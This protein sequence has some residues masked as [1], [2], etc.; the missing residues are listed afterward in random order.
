MSFQTLGPNQTSIY[1]R[2]VSSGD[3]ANHSG[4]LPTVGVYFDEM[5]VTTI[6]GTLDMNMYDTS[7]IEVLPGPQGTLYGASS[8]AGTVRIISN[9]ATPDKFSAGYSLEGNTTAGAGG[10]DLDGF[11]NVPLGDKAAIRLVGWGQRTAGYLDNVYAT[12]TYTTSGYT[13]NDKNF[14]G[15]NENPSTNNGGRGSLLLN[16]TPHWSVTLNAMGEDQHID[17]FYGYLPEVG[18]LKVERFGPD[19]DHDSWGMAGLTVSGK[20]GDY[21]LTYSG[22]FFARH[23]YQKQDYTDYTIFYDALYGTGALWQDASGHPL[24]TPQQNNL[25]DYHYTKYSNELRLASPQTDRLRFIAGVYQE[26]QRHHIIQNQN[27]VDQ[28]YDGDGYV[29]DTY[30]PGLSVPNYDQTQWLTNQERI[31]RDVAAFTEVSFDIMPRLTLLAGVRPYYYDNSIYGFFGYSQGFDQLSGY[32]SGPGADRQNCIGYLTFLN[33]PC[34]NLDKSVHGSGETHKA[35]LTYKFNNNNLVYFTYSTGYRP[36]G[37]NR[38]AGFG[39]YQADTLTNYELG[40]KTS[41]LDNTLIW[42]SALYDEDWNRFQFDFLGPNAVTIIENAPEANIKGIETA[43]SWNATRQ[44]TLNGGLTLTS[45][46]LTKNICPTDSNGIPLPTCPDSDA[47][48]LK[49]SPL[50]YT[51]DVKTYASARYTFDMF[52]WHAFGQGSVTYQTMA[53]VGL[54]TSDDQEL[55]TMPGY[56]TVDISAGA[57]RNS[58]SL[59]V[60]AKNL[61]DSRG[62]EDRYT[63]CPVGACSATIPGVPH[64]VYVVPI[65]PRTIG[66]KVAQ[67]F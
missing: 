13:I 45:A 39:P 10:Y 47:V 28:G 2:G 9:K 33:T 49:G 20:I 3:N 32:S 27:F 37:I 52:D 67:T 31:D 43:I 22:G 62:Q 54:R 15:K 16:L 57:H 58:L 65:V 30:S 8:E 21:D 59:E 60:F 48:A 24:P 29:P 6:G 40:L 64:S 38:V 53:H 25:N 66:V 7:R 19:T 56:A 46:K 5:P 17:G 26:E 55:G 34:V 50:P 18:D 42:D 63:T 44:L 23:I 51:A 4:P 12:R 1:L 11:V 36:G 41:L 35:N 61:F 14:V